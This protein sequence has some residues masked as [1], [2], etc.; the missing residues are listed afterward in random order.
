MTAESPQRGNPHRL[1]VRQHVLPL[2]SVARFADSDGLVDV[3][4][5]LGA[6]NFR[7]SPRNS[8]FCA[9]RVWNQ[10]AKTSFMKE[11][12]DRFQ[13]TVDMLRVVM[14]N[15]IGP[16]ANEAITEF[17]L[18]WMLRAEHRLAPTTDA[19][20]S[21]IS[22]LEHDVTQDEDELL[23]SVGVTCIRPDYTI[24]ARHFSGDQI[25]IDS[26]K[27]GKRLRFVTWHLACADAGEFLVPDRPTLDSMMVL[28][29]PSTILLPFP[30]RTALTRLQVA[31]V[32]GSLVD[33]SVE[34]YFARDLS[35]S[36][37]APR[38]CLSP[39]DPWAA[40]RHLPAWESILAS[41]SR[42]R[43]PL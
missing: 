8:L 39:S 14:G 13:E 19:K 40:D 6:K 2:K 32:N 15:R 28:L 27:L 16:R 12:E 33:S 24:A 29:D 41:L 31:R 18:L 21:E 34:Y 30:V 5:P 17:F 4:L 9:R 10:R 36:P 1:V 3:R 23:E 38:S 35:K 26:L 25:R 42:S 20:L 37:I 7:V 22:S 11:I 43:R